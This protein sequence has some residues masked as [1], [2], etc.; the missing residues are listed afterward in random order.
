MAIFFLTPKTFVSFCS[1]LPKLSTSIPPYSRQYILL[2]YRSIQRYLWCF[3]ILWTSYSSALWLVGQGVLVANIW[4]QCC[5]KSAFNV[6][7]FHSVPRAV[8]IVHGYKVTL[9][10]LWPFRE[11]A[12]PAIVLA[13]DRPTA[14]TVFLVF[15][16]S[17]KATCFRW[18]VCP[19][20]R[21]TSTSPL[22]KVTV[23]PLLHRCVSFPFLILL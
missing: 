19:C 1:I 5:C 2:S 22:F 12:L 13:R 6:R 16:W 7:L 8:H 23:H 18:L 20:E 9:F 3:Y 15:I 17:V 4:T 14:P 10:W 11:A 21:A